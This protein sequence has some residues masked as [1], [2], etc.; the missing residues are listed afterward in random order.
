MV[1]VGANGGTLAEGNATEHGIVVGTSTIVGDGA[2]HAFSWTQDKGMVNL[3]T[4]AGAFGAQGYNSYAFGM[5]SKGKN[6]T[7]RLARSTTAIWWW[8][9][10]LW[11]ATFK[12]T[13]SSPR[14]AAC[15]TLGPWGAPPRKPTPST[16]TA[17]WWGRQISPETPTCT[18]LFGRKT[19]EDGTIVA[20]GLV[21]DGQCH[22]FAW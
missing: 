17:S 19:A 20:V 9:T 3:N 4:L 14:A 7:H 12:R 21:Q 11:Q 18:P 5:N 1:D 16:I 10:V 2:Y 8:T 15:T 22:A 6:R 13:P